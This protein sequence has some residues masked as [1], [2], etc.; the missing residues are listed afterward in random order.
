MITSIDNTNGDTNTE[1]VL[2]VDNSG[3]MANMLEETIHGI[4]EF[5]DNQRKVEGN[6]KVT[7]VFF[8]DEYEIPFNNIDLKTFPKITVE[9]YHTSGMTALLDAIGKTINIVRNRNTNPDKVIVCIITDGYENSSTEFI[10][11]VIN[12]TIKSLEK[13]NNWEFMF[14]G[15]DIDSFGVAGSLGI[16]KNKIANFAKTGRGT[17]DAFATMSV[18]AATYRSGGTDKDFDATTAYANISKAT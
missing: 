1:L 7:L 14:L 11:N 16:N 4:N 2:I 18:G 9:H 13:D 17:L 12:K 8:N 15:A 6:A 10:G 5:I 3:S